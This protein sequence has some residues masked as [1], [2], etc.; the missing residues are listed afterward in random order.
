MASLY[1]MDDMFM[2]IC[3]GCGIPPCLA[4]PAG[5][6]SLRQPGELYTGRQASRQAGRWLLKT[7]VE[8]LCS[9]VYTN[10]LLT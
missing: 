4:W 9:V 7:V 1:T 10:M 6:F 3:H 2:Y 5:L 8:C